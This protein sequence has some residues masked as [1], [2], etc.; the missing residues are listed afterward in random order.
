LRIKGTYSDV[1]GAWARFDKVLLLSN[2][3]LNEAVIEALSENPWLVSLEILYS[4]R[5]KKPQF[6]QI[7]SEDNASRH[8]TWFSFYGSVLKLSCSKAMTK[9]VIQDCH[10]PNAD[11]CFLVDGLRKAFCVLKILDLSGSIGVSCN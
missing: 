5:P 2:F 9:L 3:E 11:L 8:Q 7:M 4:R 10:I 6:C 1:K